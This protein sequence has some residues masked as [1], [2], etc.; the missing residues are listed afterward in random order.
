VPPL[1]DRSGYGY[2]VRF[3]EDLGS[4][5]LDFAAS[6][7]WAINEIRKIQKAARSKNPIVKPRWPVLI[8][9]T[10]KVCSP[11]TPILCVPKLRQPYQGWS[12]PKELQG[13]LIE[14]SFH[15]H[16]V[17]LP[18]AKSSDEELVMLQSW[19]SSYR[20]SE[21]FNKD[22]TVVP[23]ILSVIPE[24][25]EKKLGQRKESYNAYV[26]IRTPD[27]KA[28]AVKKGEQQSC[29]KAVGKFLKE[30]VKE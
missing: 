22:G 17:P 12:G 8:L 13:E 24:V 21:L 9:R 2:Q 30:V 15:S 1:T 19:L 29:M 11:S 6:L 5:D 27:W 23:E 3:V 4:I 26:P 10:P 16:Q 20:P 14:G 7:E 25:E 28:L 18:N